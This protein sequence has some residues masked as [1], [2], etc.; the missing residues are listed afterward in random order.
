MEFEKEQGDPVYTKLLNEYILEPQGANDFRGV[1]VCA[2]H[3]K[4]MEQG[5]AAGLFE[6]IVRDSCVARILVGCKPLLDSMP[7]APR[8]AEHD[9]DIDDSLP[10]NRPMEALDHVVKSSKVTVFK[11][12][13]VAPQR[14][15][16]RSRWGYGEL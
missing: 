13:G 3:E 5:D 10:Y 14:W 1:S 12:L 15:R 11:L 4:V 16:G 9:I 6:L 8:N 2:V 7:T